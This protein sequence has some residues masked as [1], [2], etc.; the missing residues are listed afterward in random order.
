M[1][2]RVAEA[3]AVR[4]IIESRFGKEHAGVET[5]GRSAAT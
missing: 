5:L 1:P 2:I 3:K 4:Q